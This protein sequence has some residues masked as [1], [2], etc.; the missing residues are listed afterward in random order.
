MK[1]SAKNN[2]D[3]VDIEED[4]MGTVALLSSANDEQKEVANKLI[5]ALGE[6]VRIRVKA[7]SDLC[8]ECLQR[9]LSSST[10]QMNNN[11]SNEK[12]PRCLSTGQDVCGHARTA[13]LF[14]GRD[15]FLSLGCTS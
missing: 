5:A 12:V 2:A 7:Q 9:Q 3:S 8:A 6:S 4:I 15:R 14:S 13:V 1:A 11:A 10:D